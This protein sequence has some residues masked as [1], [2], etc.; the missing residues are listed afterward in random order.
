[1]GVAAGAAGTQETP[2]KTSKNAMT[3]ALLYFP[4]KD[5]VCTASPHGL[6]VALLTPIIPSLP[7]KFPEIH[8]L[9]HMTC[10]IIPKHSNSPNRHSY[11][12]R[13]RDRPDD[14]STTGRQLAEYGAKSGSR[15]DLYGRPQSGR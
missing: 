15:S 4:E 2:I 8:L 3:K 14:A 5:F 10:G 1:M 11:P 6:I 13:R 12:E 9:R 7:G